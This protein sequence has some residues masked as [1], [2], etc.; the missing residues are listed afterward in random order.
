M[1]AG[2]YRENK[3]TV[4]SLVKDDV[5]L[6]PFAS[7]IIVNSVIFFFVIVI[8]YRISRFQLHRVFLTHFFVTGYRMK[9]ILVFA[10][11]NHYVTVWFIIVFT[12]LEYSTLRTVAFSTGGG[13][14]CSGNQK[15]CET[16][17]EFISSHRQRSRHSG[18]W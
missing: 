9:Y 18:Y 12:V 7:C 16:A 1:K 5:S 3:I 6:I 11:L 4:S 14:I 13:T 10:V 17:R 8:S 15:N 2:I